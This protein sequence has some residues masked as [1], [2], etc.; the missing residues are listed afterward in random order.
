MILTKT[1]SAI[2]TLLAGTL[3]TLPARADF[4]DGTR[5]PSKTQ[6]HYTANVGETTTHSLAGKY[7][8]EN[9]FAV[10]AL[11]TDGTSFQ[12]GFAGVGYIAEQFE[13]VKAIPVL[14]Y[15]ISGDGKQGNINGILQA[16]VFPNKDGTFLADPR[17]T[18]S[19]PA[20]GQDNHFPNHNFG[21]TLSAG[22]SRIRAGPDISYTVG[23][24]HVKAAGLIRYD[25][26]AKNHSSWV[27]MGMGL[28]GTV[29]LQLRGNF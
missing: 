2:I 15:G 25:F 5:G 14:G 10:G 22:N 29:Q 13:I 20:H 19:V 12:G 17:Y 6:V 3:G 28:E 9:M 18:L 11:S 8:G 23:E 16:T 27:E 21:F 24:P 4:Y 7:F 26:D 1:I